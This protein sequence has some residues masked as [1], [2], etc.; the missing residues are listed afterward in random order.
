MIRALSN[1]TF[2]QL[3]LHTQHY[4]CRPAH[5]QPVFCDYCY[6]MLHIS[7]NNFTFAQIKILHFIVHLFILHQCLQSLTNSFYFCIIDLYS[8]QTAGPVRRTDHLQH[9]IWAKWVKNSTANQTGVHNVHESH[10]AGYCRC[11]RSF[12]KYRLKSNQ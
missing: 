5:C 3:V 1:F 11:T 4:N 12:Q 7:A 9:P 2:A 6:I 10:H 8:L